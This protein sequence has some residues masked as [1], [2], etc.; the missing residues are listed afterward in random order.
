MKKVKHIPIKVCN[1]VDPKY[2]YPKNNWTLRN[3]KVGVNFE[4]RDL[5]LSLLKFNVWAMHGYSW[6]SAQI[7]LIK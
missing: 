3:D 2:P 7:F 6:L 5:I 4:Q 1:S